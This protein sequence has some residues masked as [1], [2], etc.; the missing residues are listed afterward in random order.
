[1][2]TDLDSECNNGY[3]RCTNIATM[4]I[5]HRNLALFLHPEEIRIGHH[6]RV[7]GSVSHLRCDELSQRKD[8]HCHLLSQAQA[9]QSAQVAAL[10]V[11]RPRHPPFDHPQQQSGE[12]RRIVLEFRR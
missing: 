8:Q 12:A 1:M 10:R 3:G 7:H 5:S 6:M 4:P 2:D 9:Q 11:P